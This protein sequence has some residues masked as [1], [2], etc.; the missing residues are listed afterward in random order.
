MSS[1]LLALIAG[2]GAGYM[3]QKNRNDEEARQ[4]KRDDQSQQLFDARMREIQQ[5]ESDRTALRAAG[6]PVEVANDTEFRPSQD[7]PVATG[8]YRVGA[9]K[10]AERGLADTEAAAQNSPDATRGRMS[11]AL[12]AQGKYGEATQ[13]D[14]AATQGKLAKVQLSEAESVAQH[15]KIARGMAGAIRDGG[16]QGAADFA[17][18]GYNDG[19]TYKAVED[20]KGGAT[21]QR[22]TAD[23]KP[24]GAMPF[25]KP[26]DL[27]MFTASAVDPTKYVEYKT[28]R[29]D[30]K[31]DQEYREAVRK[32]TELHQRNMERLSG[33]SAQ[34]SAEHLKIERERFD[35][36]KAAAAAEAKIPSAVKQQFTAYSKEL[37]TISGAL[38]KAQAEGSFD[39]TNPGSMELLRRQR[40]LSEKS[41]QLLKPYLS[42]KEGA[43]GG[44]DPLGLDGPAGAP[45]T[46]PDAWIRNAPPGSVTRP[47]PGAAP[48]ARAAAGLQPTETAAAPR[49]VEQA[50]A[51]ASAS[52]ALM[53]AQAQTVETIK[54]VGGALQQQQQALRAAASDPSTP[55]QRLQE[56]AA[57]VQASRN[58]LDQQLQQMQPE[59]RQAVIDALGI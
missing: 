22:F 54:Q 59:K 38:A 13:L 20:G 52:P 43:K 35:L 6:A 11:A 34:N 17:T 37:D 53:Q 42:G 31:A 23:G 24:A 18:K 32:S 58:A 49:T 50:L 56:L 9:A 16:W 39:A 36:V 26:E 47:V 14:T 46:K 15:K 21:M 7:A 28:G 27:I 5:G 10:F 1:A 12:M 2:A 55:P 8:G 30:K 44:A 51:G 41:A 45:A 19:Y 57:A 29:D 3:G 33:Q 48:A 25:A 40:T 4:A